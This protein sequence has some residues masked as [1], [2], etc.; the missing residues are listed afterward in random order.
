[1]HSFTDGTENI[2]KWFGCFITTVHDQLEFKPP[3]NQVDSNT[4]LELFA[5]YELLY[6][7]KACRIVF[8]RDESELLLFFNG[9]VLSLPNTYQQFVYDI[10]GVGVIKYKTLDANT[11]KSELIEIL[12]RFYNEGLLHF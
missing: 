8:I 6:R 7:H 10:S 3:S 9:E 2:N 5:K 1:M 11:L 12:C 4:F